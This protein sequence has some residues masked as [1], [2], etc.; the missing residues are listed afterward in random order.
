MLRPDDNYSPPDHWVPELIRF[1]YLKAPT[2]RAPD[3]RFAINH[4]SLQHNGGRMLKESSFDFDHLLKKQ[5]GTTVWHGLKFR[6]IDQLKGVLYNH[7]LL[8][9]L[10]EMFE[11]GMPYL[12]LNKLSEDKRKRELKEQVK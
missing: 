8:D 3:F 2:P 10:E 11:Q 4:N 5:E 12:D 6:P 9:Y 1:T 7:P